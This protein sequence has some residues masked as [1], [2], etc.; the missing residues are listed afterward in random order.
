M[1]ARRKGEALLGE[2]S[3]RRG[4][5][6]IAAVL[7]A[8]V[9][10]RGRAPSEG[11]MAAG[12]LKWTRIAAIAAAATLFVTV[13]GVAVSLRRGDR[14][15]TQD[16]LSEALTPA[17]LSGSWASINV[18]TVPREANS[19][20]I[21]AALLESPRFE[22]PSGGCVPDE[23]LAELRSEGGF[24]VVS[25]VDILL[26]S[27]DATTAIVTELRIDAVQVKER[28]AG[29]IRA[30]CSGAGNSRPES[31][32]VDLQH[33]PIGENLLL[34]R[35]PFRYE[36]LEDEVKAFS[37]NVHSD[38]RVYE[39]TGQVSLIVNKEQRAFALNDGGAPFVS[40]S[41]PVS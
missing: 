8:V 38:G 18:L 11:P 31:F 1:W 24:P 21:P 41:D 20:F 29:A 23:E 27:T 40:T 36:V 14:E 13:V 5:M 17:P 35:A 22:P 16:S 12:N 10:P 25:D 19:W 9:H 6:W 32:S 3:P 26:E 30:I 15:G 39:W 34:S 28:P 33:A 4:W 37:I 2:P 7:A